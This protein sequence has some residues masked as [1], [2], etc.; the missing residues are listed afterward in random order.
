MFCKAIFVCDD[1]RF[2]LGGST[3]FVG[4]HGEKLVVQAGR[5]GDPVRFPQLS[6]VTIVG[7]LAGVERI[8][9]R[10]TLRAVDAQVEPR[11]EPMRVEAH[12]PTSDEHSF[13]FGDAPMELP[14]TGVYELATELEVPGPLQA[15]YRYRFR[16]EYAP[17]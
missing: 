10:H 1:V 6:F 5:P 8:A 13:I 11:E 4:V 17:A 14:G 3:T 7:G 2:E 16:V 15:T 12:D 9:Y